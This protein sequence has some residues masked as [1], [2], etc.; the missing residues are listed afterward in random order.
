MKAFSKTNLFIILLTA[1]LQAESYNGGN[2]RDADSICYGVS[3]SDG[4]KTTTVIKSLEDNLEN[5]TIYFDTSSLFS[6]PFFNPGIDDCSVDDG[7]KSVN[8]EEHESSN[9]FGPVNMFNNG[10]WTFYLDK[11][12]TNQDRSISTYDGGSFLDKIADLFSS[13]GALKATYVKNGHLYKGTIAS[14]GDSDPATSNSYITGPFD[15]WDKD[16]D[17]ASTPPSDRNIS[18]KIVNEAFT[19]SLASLNKDSNAYELK[20]GTGDVDVAIYSKNSTTP[21]SNHVSFKPTVNP[22]MRVA[23]FT[24]TQ[25]ARDAVVG[26]KFCATYKNNV[27]TG[28]TL[29]KLYNSTA[30]PSPEPDNLNDCNATTSNDPTW[31]ICYSTDN[32]AIRPYAFRVFGG[33][34]YN[35]AGEDFNV[36]IKAV[37][38]E[39]YDK[40]D[41]S[42]YNTVI[43]TTDYNASF[44][45]LTLTSEFY[46]PT[47][48]EIDIMYNHVVG[49]GS[50][51]MD[52]KKDR[53]AKCPYPGIFTKLNTTDSFADG[54]FTARLKFS[55]T[56]ILTIVVSETP[57][58]EFAIVDSDDTNASNRFIKPSSVINSESNISRTSLLLVNP[59]SLD[60]VAEY[61]TS[62]SKEWVYMNDISSAVTSDTKPDMSAYIHYTVTAKNKDGAITKNFTSTC[63]PDTNVSCPRVNG[64]KL[65]TTYDFNLTA[66]LNTTANVNLSI[67]NGDKNHNALFI[68][69]ADQDANLLEGNNTLTK[70]TMYSKQFTD[71]VAESY[72][73]FNVDKNIS[74]AQ[75]PVTIKVIDANT[76]LSG[77][78]SASP[79]A[80]NGATLNKSYNFI[81]GRTHTQRQQFIGTEGNASIFYEVYCSGSHCNKT[82]LPNGVASK[83]A[84]DPRWFVNTIH[85]P[86]TDG[87]VSNVTQKGGASTVTTNTPSHATGKTT[88]SLH[89]DG[90]KGYPYKT[91][92]EINTAK[93]LI[94]NKYNP[95]ATTNEF[96]T[97]FISESS[98]WAGMHETNATTK[99]NASDNTNRRLMW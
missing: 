37:D 24:V 41:S 5:V 11:V 36:T 14:C 83:I 81:Y 9:N 48:N 52:T 56:G 22:H 98:G 29:Y 4:E 93:W 88:V 16:R 80:F 59:Y 62:T 92:M 77:I 10:G 3:T 34:A 30:C 60:T 82:L 68:A 49:T 39:N 67:Y 28:E 31:H 25:I 84:D 53:V 63:F 95:N 45:D 94:Y 96:E 65:N 54:N 70:A 78:N 69:S 57:G 64:L 86:S 51:D 72:V 87:K 1:S 15:A 89:Y 26:F 76:S 8:C 42:S 79:A 38:Q 18:T 46:T 74:V 40:N 99:R 66:T 20:H 7:A 71:G 32:F 73:H 44:S 33:D 43:G 17:K 61:N 91:T 13:Q 75:N 35:R 19:L 27:I 55:E 58:K 47:D 97:E 85:S 2:A 6:I 90:T 50:A 23:N 12:S 21:I